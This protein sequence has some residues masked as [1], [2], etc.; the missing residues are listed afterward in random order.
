MAMYRSH[1]AAFRSHY[2]MSFLTPIFMGIFSL[3]ITAGIV[4]DA[5]FPNDMERAGQ[6]VM[7]LMGVT[8]VLSFGGIM[9]SRGHACGMWILAAILVGCFLAV[10]PTAPAHWRRYELMFYVLGLLFPLLGL[11]SLNSERGR[12]LRLQWRII[13][14]ERKEI[15]QEM[16][17][18]KDLEKHREN[19]RKRNALRE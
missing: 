3:A 2:L 14:S 19:L 9:M 17:R 4:V 13:R 6:S 8:L 11:L 15:R 18:R 7:L 5:Y 10:L 16:R 1:V 12:E